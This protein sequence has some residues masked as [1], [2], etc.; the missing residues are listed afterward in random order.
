MINF[1]LIFIYFTDQVIFFGCS[2]DL[3]EQLGL[4]GFEKTS[5]LK[6]CSLQVL[7]YVLVHQQN[8]LTDLLF[9]NIIIIVVVEI[10]IF[11]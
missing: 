3:A 9:I 10:I 1:Y 6:V 7:Y 8:S 5:V 4:S 11:S 2:K